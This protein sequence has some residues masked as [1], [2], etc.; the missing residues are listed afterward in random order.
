M[1]RVGEEIK[2]TLQAQMVQSLIQ[3]DTQLIDKKHSGK[4]IS[5]LTYD[6][7]HITTLLSTAILNLFKDSLTLIGLLFVMF[8]QNWELSLIAI[9]MI[10]LAGIASKTLGKRMGKV[11]TEAQEKS[12]FLNTYLIELFKN[13]KLI[14]NI[15]KRELRKQKSK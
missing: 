4:F 5:N 8:F 15:S 14:K 12:G 11:V 3:A 2:K 1:I 7:T 10:P 6:V 13:H 9:I